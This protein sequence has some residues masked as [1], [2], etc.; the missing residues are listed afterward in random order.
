MLTEHRDYYHESR[1]R[2]SLNRNS[3]CRRDLEPPDRG[4]VI[5]PTTPF[6]F[7]KCESPG[8]CRPI[9]LNANELR[10]PCEPGA[11]RMGYW[12]GTMVTVGQRRPPYGLLGNLFA[13]WTVAFRR[14]PHRLNR[15]NNW[16][17]RVGLRR[18]IRRLSAR[19]VRYRPDGVFRNDT[20]HNV[21]ARRPSA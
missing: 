13:E 2:L 19:D 11:D 3:P 9:K 1:T 5:A 4:R 7:D 16:T 14:M 17:L 8:V 12:P 21:L 20:R 18:H 6:A 15:M 10:V